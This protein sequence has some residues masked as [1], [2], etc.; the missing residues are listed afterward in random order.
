MKSYQNSGK[1]RISKNNPTLVNE[2]VA[3]TGFTL[4][5]LPVFILIKTAQV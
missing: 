1:V 5:C 2:K 4:D 3:K